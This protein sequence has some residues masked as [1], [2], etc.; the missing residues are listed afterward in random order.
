MSALRF[1]QGR[2]DLRRRIMTWTTWT[3]I[4]IMRSKKLLLELRVDG[5]RE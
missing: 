1:S 4:G 2:W 5:V 3:S